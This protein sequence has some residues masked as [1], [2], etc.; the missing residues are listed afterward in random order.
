MCCDVYWQDLADALRSLDPLGDGTLTF[1]EFCRAVGSI[2]QQS[3]TGKRNKN[4]WWLFIFPFHSCVT[5]VVEIPFVVQEEN[6]NLKTN[7]PQ[8]TTGLSFLNDDVTKRNT[9]LFCFF[10]LLWLLFH[11]RAVH[12]RFLSKARYV[13]SY[14]L[15]NSPIGNEI[16]HFSTS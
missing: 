14:T 3:T 4:K 11:P 6:D 8:T 13:I 12:V 7:R 10:V 1:D 15:L 9:W 5:H 16:T 2:I